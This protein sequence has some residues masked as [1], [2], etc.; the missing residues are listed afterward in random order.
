MRSLESIL[1]VLVVVLL[2]SIAACAT[3]E[4]AAEETA[5][6]TEEVADETAE[7]GEAVGEEAA[8]IAGEAAEEGEEAARAVA[9]ETAQGAD[10]AEDFFDLEVTIDLAARGADGLSGDADLSHGDDARRIEIELEGTPSASASSYDAMVARGTCEQQN[11]QAVE[12]EGFTADNDGLESVTVFPAGRL[13]A[14]NAPYS[15]RVTGPGGG[16]VSCG[17]IA[18]D[19]ID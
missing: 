11:G 16:L 2:I 6:T 7:A 13:S 17:E 1:G 8:D 15:I 12:L 3:T 4:D 19:D 10:R 9:R 14:S 5:E 18:A